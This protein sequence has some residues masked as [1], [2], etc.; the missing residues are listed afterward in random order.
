MRIVKST[1]LSPSF[2]LAVWAALFMAIGCDISCAT[3]REFARL[4]FS[5]DS[6]ILTV[7]SSRPVAKAVEILIERYIA[8]ITY[9]DPQYAYS[10][11]MQ[12]VASQVRRDVDKLGS[13]PIP[14]VIVPRGGEL[15]IRYPASAG[16]AT[17]L[18]KLVGAG[19]DAGV[20]PRFRF[21][22]SKGMYHIVPAEA[23]GED[24][25]WSPQKSV[26]DYPI[27]IPEVDRDA[28]DLLRSICIA[29]GEAAGVRVLLGVGLGSG[30]VDQDTNASKAGEMTARPY[31]LGADN[32]PAREV[33]MRALTAIAPQHGNLTWLLYF[34]NEQTER[35][36]VLNLVSV[37]EVASQAKPESPASQRAPSSTSRNAS[38]V[39]TT[40][41]AFE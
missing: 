30:P 25:G 26:L 12:D 23:K 5:G 29:T 4:E 20:S 2:V 6:A 21:L 41:P 7:E 32:E 14:K 15:A 1:N 16:I 35:K 38:E 37:P 39:P 3:T 11:D 31:R 40:S 18:Q 8:A 10:G 9:E 24:G 36:Y 27:S 22:Q 33:L 28:Y 19:A 13:A 34:G 17:I